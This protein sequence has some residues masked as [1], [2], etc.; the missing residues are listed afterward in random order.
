MTNLNGL[1]Q[2][3]SLSSLVIEDNDAL[4]SL[5]GLENL[6]RLGT[7]PGFKFKVEITGNSHLENLRGLDSLDY[8]SIR[9][10]R[11]QYNSKL[12]VC[13]IPPVCAYVKTAAPA[14]I[15]GNAPGCNSKAE[16][17]L[18]CQTSPAEEPA[19]EDV[20]ILVYPNPVHEA[21]QIQVNESSPWEIGISDLRGRLLYRQT[22][23]GSRTIE[24]GDWPSGLYTLRATAGER[25]YVGR[26]V[27]Q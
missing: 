17:Q 4:T 18:A 12:S 2:I 7:G 14:T 10:L 21:L 6:R 19:V 1:H 23:S 20:A 13:N 3:D 8:T 27:K 26:F 24:V 16:I 15:V 5:S 25:V 11:L 22:I 9:E